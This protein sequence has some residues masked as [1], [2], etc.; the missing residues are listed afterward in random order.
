MM[1]TDEGLSRF[2]HLRNKQG[3]KVTLTN[4]GASMVSAY[5][6]DRR[7]EFADILLGYDSP[8]QYLDNPHYLGSVCGRYAN[9]IAGGSFRLKGG[10]VS[11]A[12]NEGKNCLHG[13]P[14]GFDCRLWD[15]S[16]QSEK[17]IE[18][19]LVSKDGDQGFPGNVMVTTTYT[20]TEE[21]RLILDCFATTDA[22]TVLNLTNHSYFNLRGEGNGDILGHMLKVNA[23]QFTPIDEEKLPTGLIE[24]LLHTPF[25]FTSYREIGERLTLSGRQLSF[26]NGYDHN[27]VLNRNEQG[28]LEY[29][30]SLWDTESGRRLK[31]YTTQPGL[32]V[33]TGNF[34]NV[35]NGKGGK[36]Y[37]KHSGVA[38]ET[39]HFP[40]SPNVPHFPST[41]L[42]T[43]MPYTSQTVFEFSVKS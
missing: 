39:Q 1:E 38:L 28:K 26:G 15:V 8:S 27:W 7:G 9:R 4:C 29:A 6:A 12:V 25:D 13:G 34:L 32:Q 35:A 11:L 40:N 20:L 31:I 24:T 22:P 42:S 23:S 16:F 18:F 30:A 19:S 17:S 14:Q 2:F 21:N 41:I 33:Y 37:G 43:E 36:H 10:V 3:L 5:V